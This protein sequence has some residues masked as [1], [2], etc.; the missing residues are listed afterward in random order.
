MAAMAMA[1]EAIVMSAQVVSVTLTCNE[2]TTKDITITKVTSATVEATRAV[3]A[4]KVA[5]MAAT[6]AADIVNK[7]MA[8]SILGSP[9]RTL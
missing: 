8:T 6:V 4:L 5:S 9:L 2:D 3:E 7:V 1:M